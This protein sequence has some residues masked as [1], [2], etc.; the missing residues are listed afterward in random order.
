V[1][2]RAHAGTPLATWGAMQLLKRILISTEGR[3]R[4]GSGGA[5]IAL[6]LLTVMCGEH[7]A[8]VELHEPADAGAAGDA[9]SAD[10]AAGRGSERASGDAGGTASG[11]LRGGSGDSNGGALD[12]SEGT[13]GGNGSG[14]GATSAA[15]GGSSGSSSNSSNSAGADVAGDACMPDDPPCIDGCP[16]DV[17]YC[18]NPSTDERIQCR[19]VGSGPDCVPTPCCGRGVPSCEPDGCDSTAGSCCSDKEHYIDVCRDSNGTVSHQEFICLN[20]CT[21]RS[22]GTGSC[23]NCVVSGD[24]PCDSGS[25]WMNGCNLAVPVACSDPVAGYRLECLETQ[26]STGFKLPNVTVLCTCD[27][28]A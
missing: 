22:Y 6:G 12:A 15:R 5:I 21:G 25:R 2:L 26:D 27:S 28:G 14:A 18:C 13:A 16:G 4:L 3:L 7:D 10:T 17:D 19:P 20:D 23:A 1:R 9:L 11:T 8:K 24:P